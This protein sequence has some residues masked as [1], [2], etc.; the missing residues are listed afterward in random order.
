MVNLFED[1]CNQI[2]QWM[3]LTIVIVGI[4]GNLTN[5]AVF[6]RPVFNHH[7]CSSYYC[8]LAINNFFYSC[9]V[10]IYRVLTD[11]FHIQAVTNSLFLCRFTNFINIF[12]TGLSYYLIILSAL[13][14]W[15]ARSTNVRC[16]HINSFQVMRR[17][18]FVIIILCVLIAFTGLLVTELDLNDKL[19]CCIRAT[20]IYNQ[21]Y[22]IIQFTLFAIVAPILMITFTV[23]TI[24]KRKGVNNFSIAVSKC[25]RMEYHLTQISFL[26]V[27]AHILLNLTQWIEFLIVLRPNIFEYYTFVQIFIRIPIYSSFEVPI[28]W[29]LILGR[30]FR[31]EL[32]KILLM[33]VPVYRHIQFNDTNNNNLDEYVH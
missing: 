23:L 15:S 22:L 20:T 2:N 14:R 1:I 3:I 26:L 5:I 21:C 27:F 12:C 16:R 4:V 17:L 28:L 25:R 13:D 32:G 10:L 11:G 24:R 9:F 8:A 18:I 29:Y 6:V 30:E 33:F 31:R 7:V 19:G